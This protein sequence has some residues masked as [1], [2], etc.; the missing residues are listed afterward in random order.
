MDFDMLQDMA[1]AQPKDVDDLIDPEEQVATE[2]DESSL[3]SQSISASKAPLVIP[4]EITSLGYFDNDQQLMSILSGDHEN[5]LLDEEDDNTTE[6][7]TTI[8]TTT[9]NNDPKDASMDEEQEEEEEEIEDDEKARQALTLM[10]AEYGD[11]L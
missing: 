4:Q 9:T 6:I 1:K 11:Q 2:A 5:L 8:T 3:H 7:P 10:L